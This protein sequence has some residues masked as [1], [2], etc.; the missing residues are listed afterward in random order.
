MFDNILGTVTDR[1]IELYRRSWAKYL[2]HCED[3][4]LELTTANAVMSWRLAMV[5]EGFSPNTI[6]SHLSAIKTIFKANIPTG[7]ISLETYA[8]VK[9]VGSVS[10]RALRDRLRPAKD[11]LTDESV[12]R[13]INA[14]DLSSL[15]GIRDRAILCLLATTGVRIEE[16]STLT[17]ESY[18]PNDNIL[19][20]RGKTDTYP[21]AVPL[22]EIAKQAVG[23]WLYTRGNVSEYIFNGFYGT[24]GVLRSEAIST[25]GAY[26]IITDRAKDVGVDI[27]PHDFRRYVATK[28][29]ETNIVDAQSVLGH[30]SI[31]TT[32]RY[33][34]QPALP[35]VNWLS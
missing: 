5:E 9:A 14:I 26:A 23:L 22:S 19:Y 2:S 10:V 24:T 13:I 16:L 6:N 7:I 11:K 35:S 21:R 33:V 18:K 28:L 25:Q 8:M 1:T 32:Q 34:R 17:L 27:A 15:G 30:R 12:M 29:A 4:A 31:V 20:V 3:N